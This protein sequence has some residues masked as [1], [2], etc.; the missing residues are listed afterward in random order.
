MKN[1]FDIIVIIAI[2]CILS[3][4]LILLKFLIK[5]RS[6]N[7]ELYQAAADRTR[8]ENLNKVIL[9]EHYIKEDNKLV[10]APYEVDYGNG[11]SEKPGRKNAESSKGKMSVMLQLVENTELSTRKFI[12]NPA[13]KIRIGS[14]FTDNDIVVSDSCIEEHQCEIFLAQGKIYIKNIGNKARTIIRRKKEQVIV[15]GKG[16]RLLTGDIVLTGKVT[17]EVTII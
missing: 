14:G 9:N 16:I 6:K 4:C 2:I 15:D 7:K 12:L 1:L 5:R 3:I 13:K 17:Y 10:K 8:D 11:S